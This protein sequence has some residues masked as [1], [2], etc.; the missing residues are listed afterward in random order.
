M[1]GHGLTKPGYILSGLVVKIISTILT[2]WLSHDC[3]DDPMSKQPDQM[4]PD[5]FDLCRPDLDNTVG[6][7]PRTWADTGDLN[8]FRPSVDSAFF[9]P[10]KQLAL[11]NPPPL[12]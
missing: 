4:T 11:E 1:G 8:H 2:S 12:T 3:V 10:V 6:A 5:L 9:P 7:S